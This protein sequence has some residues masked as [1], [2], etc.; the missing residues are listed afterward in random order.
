MVVNYE[1]ISFKCSP[2]DYDYTS[3]IQDKLFRNQS[4]LRRIPFEGHFDFHNFDSSELKANAGVVTAR[5]GH[6]FTKTVKNTDGTDAEKTFYRYQ[7]LLPINHGL[8]QG[9][10]LPAGVHVNL[11]FHRADAKKG[12]IFIKNLYFTIF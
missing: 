12:R 10:I 9:Q 4:Y 11:T 5:R 3:F 2:N 6:E 7:L 1:D 8:C